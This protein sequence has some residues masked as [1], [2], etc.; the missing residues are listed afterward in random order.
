M[1]LRNTPENYGTVAKW[2][3]WTTAALFLA[4]YISVYYRQWFTEPRTP[5]SSTALQIHLSIGISIAV[6]VT[7]RVIWRS[8]NRVPEF[9]PGSNLQHRA[10]HLG[11]YALYAIMIIM[12]LTGYL[13]T[14]VATNFFFLFEVPKFG[15]TQLF[16]SLV[17]GWLGMT[18]KEWEAP[19]DFIHKEILGAWVVWLLILG[20]AAAAMYHHFVQRDRTLQKMTTAVADSIE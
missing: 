8:M 5:E 17:A 7:L 3:H 16:S 2:L 14:G 13:G 20:H 11:H 6:I 9:E 4:A 15:D 19:I 12:P 1:T 18:F 10:A